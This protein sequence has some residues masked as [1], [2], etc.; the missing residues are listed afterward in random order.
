MTSGSFKI[1]VCSEKLHGV[2]QHSTVFFT[3]TAVTNVKVKLKEIYLKSSRM[4]WLELTFGANTKAAFSQLAYTSLQ[5]V[6][7]Q[8]SVTV[9]VV[10]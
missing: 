8:Q 1:F 5:Y 9:N 7:K 10:L 4:W 3:S 6:A 2:K